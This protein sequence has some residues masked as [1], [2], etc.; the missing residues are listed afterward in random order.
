MK[1]L[2]IIFY[3]FNYSLFSQVDKSKSLI[4]I[5]LQGI[6]KVYHQYY[7][8]LNRD[9]IEYRV[10]QSDNDFI[11][12]VKIDTKVSQ[13]I[14]DKAV[15]II[16]QV[17]IDTTKEVGLYSSHFLGMTVSYNSQ[18]KTIYI[19]DKYYYSLLEDIFKTINNNIISSI[20]IPLNNISFSNKPFEIDKKTNHNSFS[21]DWL[22]NFYGDAKNR[23]IYHNSNYK[24]SLRITLGKEKIKM[25]SVNKTTLDSLNILT[26]ACINEF[27]FNSE[28]IKKSAK[29]EEFIVY[30]H[31]K[32][33]E[34]MTTFTSFEMANKNILFV[35]L[36]NY[37]NKHVIPAAPIE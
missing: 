19:R 21:I 10:E 16:E 23:S 35:Q 22:Y 15:N 25:T 31:T 20:Q 17:K 6:D 9:T 3:L 28:N 12:K 2:I 36:K 18:Q 37:I 24:D 13:Q 33:V 7:L 30:Q 32:R 1:R 8:Y 26:L 29:Y 14:I 4:Y 5:E 11:K 27:K 34:I